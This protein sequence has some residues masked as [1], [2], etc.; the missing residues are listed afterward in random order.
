MNTIT[1]IEAFCIV[2]YLLIE[3]VI[4]MVYCG[5]ERIHGIRGVCLK[6]W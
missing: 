2:V 4:G 6:V 5:D 1:S 3:L